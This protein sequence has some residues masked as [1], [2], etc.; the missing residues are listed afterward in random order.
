MRF[1]W[2]GDFNDPVTFLDLFASD[3]AQNLPA[4]IDPGYDRL[5][6]QAEN[7]VAA[8]TRARL[9][10]QAEERLQRSHAVIPLYFYVSKHM[11]NASLR[12]FKDNVRNVHPSRFLAF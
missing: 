10:A 7:T 9:L 4:Y 1:S 12:G 8:P 3:S 5:L 6:D 2:F 11:V